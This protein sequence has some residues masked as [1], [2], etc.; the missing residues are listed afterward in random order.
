MECSCRGVPWAV[1]CEISH[2]TSHTWSPV[3]LAV[4]CSCC[5]VLSSCGVWDFTIF[6]ALL[7]KWI[8][9]TQIT[10]FS[11]DVEC[12]TNSQSRDPGENRQ[13]IA[14]TA[15]ISLST[16]LF[17]RSLVLCSLGLSRSLS[18]PLSL[19]LCLSLCL[20]LSRSFY[21]TRVIPSLCLFLSPSLTPSHS[22]YPTHFISLSLS[23]YPFLSL[24]LS[25][26][27]SMVA[28]RVSQKIFRQ[29]QEEDRK[30]EWNMKWLCLVEYH[31]IGFWWRPAL[32]P[33]TCAGI[34]RNTRDWHC[35]RAS[36]LSVSRRNTSVFYC[37]L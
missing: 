3:Q 11:Q 4:E 31:S 10:L 25:L 5:G 8:A 37:K 28:V 1:E 15:N 13:G 12:N 9:C 23:L 17:S 2:C 21:P 29:N 24:F 14:F 30:H 22:L 7:A 18:L 26:T 33:H 19:S 36:W 35:G 6:V 34:P 32:S 20:S 27:R 16:S